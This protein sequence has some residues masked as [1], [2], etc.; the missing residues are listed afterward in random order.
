MQAV[1]TV[2]S[3]LLILPF[4]LAGCGSQSASVATVEDPSASSYSS[5]TSSIDE[6]DEASTSTEDVGYYNPNT[7]Y[8]ANY[9]LEVDHNPDGTVDR[10]NF[11]N[12]GYIG[13]H[14]ITDQEDNGD[15]TVTVHTDRGQEFTVEKGEE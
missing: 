7:G 15:G 12:G 9:D 14:H 4:I 8:E 2:R 5:S 3:W 6:Q 1:Q 11:D 10:I 13:S